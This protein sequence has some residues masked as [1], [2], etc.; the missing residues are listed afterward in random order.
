MKSLAK[1]SEAVN[2][3]AATDANQLLHEA[4]ATVH[5]CN[6]PPQQK[7]VTRE[8]WGMQTSKTRQMETR[9][10]HAPQPSL[11]ALVS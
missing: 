9:A 7:T 1:D 3:L 8:N 5:T 4:A 11:P 2:T 6:P 10:W